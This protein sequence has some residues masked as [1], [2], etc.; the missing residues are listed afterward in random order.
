VELLQT[1][2]AA[3]SSSPTTN[4]S[5]T[6]PIVYCD[7]NRVNSCIYLRWRLTEFVACRWIGSVRRHTRHTRVRSSAFAGGAEGTS[8]QKTQTDSCASGHGSP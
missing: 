1:R 8:S 7:W 3:S 2:T 6:S 5:K 4:T